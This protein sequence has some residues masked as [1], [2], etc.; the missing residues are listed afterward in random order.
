M[1]I[2]PFWKIHLASCEE[3]ANDYP[4]NTFKVVVSS[5]PYKKKDGYT[6]ELL[7][8]L[9]IR[10]YRVTQEKGLAFI[11][12]ASLVESW[13]RP[14][15]VYDFFI[16]A[17]W[18]PVT[19]IAWV[20]SMVFPGLCE[21]PGSL[22][23]E[24]EEIVS[25]LEMIRDSNY[26][27]AYTTRPDFDRKIEALF[28]LLEPRQ[29]GHYTPIDDERRMNNL[30]EYIHVFAKGELPELDR[31]TPPL[32]VPYADKSNLKRGNRGK[33]GDTH[34]AGNVWFIPYGTRSGPKS[35]HPHEYPLELV[36]RCI[37][38]AKAKPGDLLLDPFCGGGSTL[39]GAKQMGISG[40]A[41][42]INADTAELARKRIADFSV[43]PT[44]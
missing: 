41:Y 37:T 42:E 25:L 36:T 27:N 21:L 17:G 34:C 31:F 19:T 30:W 39:I 2:D 24:V 44:K 32:G 40:V 33:R 22:G 1:T 13:G 28:K 11:N 35:A 12:F 8:E 9:A 5:P 10:L 38:L 43:I 18:K 3:C 15:D 14:F 20:K 23:E 26:G 4:E 7:K 6:D 16:E 29:V